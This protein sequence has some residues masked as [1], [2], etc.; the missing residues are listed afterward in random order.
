MLGL[1]LS[2]IPSIIFMPKH[3]YII[4]L[5]PIFSHA[6]IF[7]SKYFFGVFSKTNF[8]KPSLILFT[9]FL[10]LSSF[11]LSHKSVQIDDRILLFNRYSIKIVALFISS[12]SFCILFFVNFISTNDSWFR[13]KTQNIIELI[14]H[15]FNKIFLKKIVKKTTPIIIIF[16]LLITSL[17][18][19]IFKNKEGLEII[20]FIKTNT[21]TPYNLIS[22][23]PESYIVNL[24][25]D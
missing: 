4:Q 2:I 17:P 8:K 10:I 22:L 20:D 18:N 24:Y 11:L 25:P 16:I 1:I 9:I 19:K 7:L 15:I 21:N 13:M 12:I 5:S 23:F 14:D 6:I 3:S